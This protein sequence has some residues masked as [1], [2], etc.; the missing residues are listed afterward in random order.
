[1]SWDRV[2]DASTFVKS[3]D[4][5]RVQVLDIDRENDPPK[6][7]LGMKQLLED[8]LIAT[9]GTLEVGETTT[10]KVTRLAAFGAFVNVGGVEG[11][12]HIS[13]LSNQRIKSAK[14]VVKEG[15]VITVRVLS[16]DPSTR[17]IAL[18]LK[19]AQSEDGGMDT[20]MREEDPAIRKLREKFGGGELKGGIDYKS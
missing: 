6:I 4:L 16:I 11:L 20:P 14:E 8:P 15:E 7:A 9:M 2:S 3:G 10:G 5:V 19:Q 12:V 17:R 1:M 18:S 13:E